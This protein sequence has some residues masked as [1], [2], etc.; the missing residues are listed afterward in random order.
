[1][2]T[3]HTDWLDHRLFQ[4]SH[5]ALLRSHVS[6]G[7]TKGGRPPHWV[8]FMYVLPLSKTFPWAQPVTQMGCRL[9][10]VSELGCYRWVY[11][12]QT[13][14]VFFKYLT[15]TIKGKSEK[16]GHGWT[17]WRD[18][19]SWWSPFC[20]GSPFLCLFNLCLFNP[21]P[22][23]CSALDTTVSCHV[24][25]SISYLSLSTQPKQLEVLLASNALGLGRSWWTIASQIAAL[26]SFY[27]TSWEE[28]YTGMLT[29]N[30]RSFIFLTV[31]V[32]VLGQLFFGYFSGPVEG[33][34]MIVIIFTITGFY[35][36]QLI[37][38]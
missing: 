20:F 36:L 26:A 34:I 31:R 10:S 12:R 17:P 7:K 21:D 1:M 16:D 18:F 24:V 33:I 22:I 37:S 9:V 29:E 4:L 30:P 23:G 5:N 19:R 13:S 35:G 28:Y 27:L 11:Y 6:Y 3:E 8:Y 2:L 38:S 15:T 14:N 32:I 25:L